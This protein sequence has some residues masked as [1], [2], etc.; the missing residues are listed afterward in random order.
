MTAGPTFNEIASPP[1]YS[2]AAAGSRASRHCT[3]PALL[4]GL[5]IAALNFATKGASIKD[6][7]KFLVLFDTLPLVGQ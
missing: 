7:G 3:A 6:V 2:A 4:V 5:F 1:L